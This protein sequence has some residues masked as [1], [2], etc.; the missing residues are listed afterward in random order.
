MKKVILGIACSLL[1]AACG[2][3]A[4]QGTA[5]G[6]EA[7]GTH[8]AGSHS[9]PAT[10][11]G[12]D[13]GSEGHDHAAQATEPS[14]IDNAE[15]ATLKQSVQDLHDEVMAK[16]GQL[17]SYKRK[18]IAAAETIDGE[19][20]TQLTQLATNL[21]G[22]HDSMMKWMRAYGE[23]VRSDMSDEDRMKFLEEKKAEMEKI[24]ANTEAAL[25]QAK[26]ALPEAI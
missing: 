4:Q 21:E 9:E 1:L 16:S 3:N 15:L 10:A 5:E 18:A 6:S 22:A 23:G 24:K 12:H 8:E 13:H 20:S 17:M 26:S 14:A 25:K 19:K 2:G 7:Q 11:E